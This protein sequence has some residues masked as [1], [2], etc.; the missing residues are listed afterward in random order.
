[1][2]VEP[3][4]ARTGRIPSSGMLGP[5]SSYHSAHQQQQQQVTTPS[6]QQQHVYANQHSMQNPVGMGGGGHNGFTRFVPSGQSLSNRTT[7]RGGNIPTSRRKT[8][9]GISGG[10]ASAPS[11]PVG[12][13]DLY[14]PEGDMDPK[15]CNNVIKKLCTQGNITEVFAVLEDM[16]ARGCVPDVKTFKT[17][18]RACVKKLA[19]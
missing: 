5:P 13:D 9:M 12:V 11:S 3:G 18:M 15:R 19:W 6:H 8:G 10:A 1:M 4:L 14:G 2:E 17:I 7:P 16:L